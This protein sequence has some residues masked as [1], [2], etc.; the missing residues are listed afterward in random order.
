V[1]DE[2]SDA[3]S[4]DVACVLCESPKAAPSMG[5]VCAEVCLAV[6]TILP[7]SFFTIAKFSSI[8]ETEQ[9]ALM[10]LR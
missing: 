7:S 10:N 9:A 5:E 2:G 4:D 6:L 3:F 1:S 8:T